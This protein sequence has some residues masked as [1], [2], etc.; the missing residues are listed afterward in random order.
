MCAAALAVV[1]I[2]P[3]VFGCK[4]DRFGG[5]GSLLHLHKPE[6]NG[7]NGNGG[8]TT[9]STIVG[10]IGSLGDEITRGV[11]E[12]ETIALLLSFY[13]RENFQPLTRNADE[14]MKETFVLV[15]HCRLLQHL[16]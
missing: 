12:T 1:G 4:N 10:N 2:R 13:N 5:C 8:T 7:G 11:L 15:V 9:D 3:V 14:R 16:T 6:H